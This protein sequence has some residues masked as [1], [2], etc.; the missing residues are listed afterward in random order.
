[1]LCSSVSRFLLLG[2]SC[3]S[4]FIQLG[5]TALIPIRNRQYDWEDN[6]DTPAPS[7][8]MPTSSA[9]RST[10]TP[11]PS[12][13]PKSSIKSGNT[14]VIIPYYM[15]PSD[16]AW[17]PLEQLVTEHS[18][19]RFTVI[20]NPSS[21]PGSSSLPDEN[22]RKAVTKLASHSNVLLIG[23]V[24]TSWG[25][26]PIS[27][28]ERDIKTYA[29]WPSVSGDSSFAVRGIFLDEGAAEYNGNKVSYYTQLNS[30]IKGSEGLGPNHYVVM[31]P[32][33]V[34]D[35]A[36]LNIPDS[37]VIF[38]S[39]HAQ[40]QERVSTGAFEQ[41]KNVDKGRLASMVTH[42]P[43]GTDLSQLVSQQRD[44]SGHI[45]LTKLDTYLAYCPSWS[46]MARLI[47]SS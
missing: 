28:V 36:Y 9:A 20:V 21:G 16:G 1:M 37:S 14:E 18:S 11:S 13:T 7:A 24:S 29:G 25:D 15:Y 32:G 30:L 43:E 39:P 33:T 45:Y 41:I 31:N 27:D 34:P 12:V 35:A 38:E 4:L 23:Y 46:E 19:V 6:D 17:A 5:H 44:I 42:V 10:A 3:L 22:Y 26:R 40:F 2:L 8:S 47:G